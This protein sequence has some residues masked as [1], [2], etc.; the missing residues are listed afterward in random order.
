MKPVKATHN[1]NIR[2]PFRSKTST[3]RYINV[4][5]PTTVETGPVAF[6]RSM[7][8][9]APKPP[10]RSTGKWW[11]LWAQLCWT[12][13]MWNFSREVLRILVTGHPQK[14][15]RQQGTSKLRSQL[16]Q[17]SFNM[18]HVHCVNSV[19]SM[20][21]PG[22]IPYPSIS[23]HIIISISINHHIFIHPCC[24]DCTVNH[25]RTNNFYPFPGLRVESQS[26]KSHMQGVTSAMESWIIMNRGSFPK[27]LPTIHGIRGSLLYGVV[28]FGF[29]PANL[30]PAHLEM[31]KPMANQGVPLHPHQSCCRC[32]TGEAPGWKGWKTLVAASI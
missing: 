4:G 3:R 32:A 24:T 27:L 20:K 17:N 2:N 10:G 5:S 15:G 9:K 12:S 23:I 11:K 6:F 13:P 21:W 25:T 19:K 18:L 1:R 22:S 31:Q 14:T 7:R 29:L 26:D 8:R 28:E 16:Q 30:Q